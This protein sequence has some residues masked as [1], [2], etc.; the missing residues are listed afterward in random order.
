[1]ICGIKR[2]VAYG[3]SLI[4]AAGIGE[5]AVPS[6]VL[7]E[8]VKTIV[9]TVNDDVISSHDVEQR[10]KLAMIA[11]NGQI[12]KEMIPR[13]RAQVVR[14]LVDEKLRLQE[15]KRLDVPATDAD[16]RNEIEVLAKD[17]GQTYDQFKAQLASKGIILRTIEEQIRADMVWSMLVRGRYGRSVTIADVDVDYAY[18]RAVAEADQPSYLVSEIFLDIPSAEQE[19]EVFKDAKQLMQQIHKGAPFQTMAQQFS[20]SISAA[21]GGDLGWVTAR[22]VDPEVAKALET[23]SSGQLSQPIRTR[24]GYTLLLVRQVRVPGRGDPMQSKI[25]LRQVFFGFGGQPTQAQANQLMQSAAS[26]RGQLSGCSNLEQVAAKY[27]NAVAVDSEHFVVKD[28]PQA[29]QQVVMNLGAGQAA[30]PVPSNRGVH[31]FIVC[32]R[33]DQK[34]EVV[35]PTR[36]EVEQRLYAQQLNM[37][38][39]RYIRDLRADAIIEYR[40]F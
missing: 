30:N 17:N 29:L 8:T 31:I 20:Q 24:E 15:A 23:L 28:L 5:I 10:V 39:K 26:A 22:D 33:T 25:S 37:Y 7:A 18:E 40:Q 1:M 2:F 4:F 14:T 32:S 19:G 27:E 3:L 12:P 6:D 38:A 9:A 34:V 16:I 36:E 21:S 13:I 11:A 35:K